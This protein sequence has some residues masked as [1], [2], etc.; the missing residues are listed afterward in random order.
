MPKEVKQKRMHKT[1]IANKV[2][3]IKQICVCMCVQNV[4]HFV[5]LHSVRVL[6]SNAVALITSASCKTKTE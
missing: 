4:F 6:I 1:T 3:T 2:A 5:L